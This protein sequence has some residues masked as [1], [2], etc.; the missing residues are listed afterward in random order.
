VLHPV[1]KIARLVHSELPHCLYI[2]DAISALATLE[3]DV[4]KTDIDILVGGSQKGLM[5]PPGLALLV[6]SSAA[7]RQVELQKRRSFYFDLIAERDAHRKNTS[8]WTPALN[9][10]LGLNEALRMLKEEG[11]ANVY[12]RHSALSLETRK[13]LRAMNFTLLAESYPAPGVTGA[14]PPSG[15]D[16]EKLRKLLLADHGV[17]IAGGQAGLSGKIIRIGHMGY[18]H[19]EGLLSALGAVETVLKKMKSSS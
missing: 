2:V 17:R 11:L 10:I 3:I 12:A 19:L 1:P 8:A 9:L 13:S 18:V 16:A 4:Q 14:F 6:L 15:I 7:W 5:L